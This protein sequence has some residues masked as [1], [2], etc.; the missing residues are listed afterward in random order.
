[1]FQG[2]IESQIFLWDVASPSFPSRDEFKGE[3]R[4][5]LRGLCVDLQLCLLGCSP[6]CLSSLFSPSWERPFSAL[7]TSGCYLPF[8]A[9]HKCFLLHEA[10]LITLCTY[11]EWPVNGT[12]FRIRQPWAQI[13]VLPAVWASPAVTLSL[14]FPPVQWGWQGQHSP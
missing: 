4:G 10:S 2:E 8:R 13:Q 14:S 3:V 6:L 1:M 12:G 7:N 5:G 9:Q 11:S